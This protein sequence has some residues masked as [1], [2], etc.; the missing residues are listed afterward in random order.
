MGVH[1]TGLAGDDTQVMRILVIEDEPRLARNL[2]KA[3]R[4]EGYAVDTAETGDEGLFKAETCDYD[5]VV[6]D[7]ML[8]GLDGW[9]VLER[10]PL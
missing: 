2:A 5:V 7:V 6:L 3:M 9:Q 1:A 4:E 10:S 8:P